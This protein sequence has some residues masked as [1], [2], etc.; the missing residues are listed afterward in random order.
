MNI[1]DEPVY[2]TEKMCIFAKSNP[3]HPAARQKNKV[4]NKKQTNNKKNKDLK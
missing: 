3:V 2:N 1:S 4:Y